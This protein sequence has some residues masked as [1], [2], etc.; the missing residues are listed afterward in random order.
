LP[1][2]TGAATSALP[3]AGRLGRAA[4]HRHVGQV[5][6]DHLL[7]GIQAS[8]PQLIEDSQ[9]DPLVPAAAQGGGRAGGVGD[10][11]VAGAEDQRLDELVEDHDVVD[12]G[13]VT[14][15]RVLIDTRGQEGEEL[16][17]QRV[18]D[19]RWNGRHEASTGHGA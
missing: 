4:V 10:P 13:S 16:L 7:V 5:Q 12:A 2:S 19:A 15:Q 8:Q 9:P 18:K 14:A 6:A 11:L 3:A 1:R 17:A